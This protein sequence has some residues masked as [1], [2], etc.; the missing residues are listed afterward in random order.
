MIPLAYRVTDDHGRT[1]GGMVAFIDPSYFMRLYRLLDLDDGG[2]A[3]LL[4]RN[5]VLLTGYPLRPEWVGHSFADSALLASIR[6]ASGATMRDRGLLNDVPRV[7]AV[8]RHGNSPL[9]VVVSMTEHHVLAQWRETAQQFGS[10]AVGSALL[11]L[12][13]LFLLARQLGIAETARADLRQSAQRLDGIIQSAMDAIITVDQQ[14]RILLFN[15][16][17]ERVF[18][19]PAS[20]VIGSPLERFLPTRF[21][22]VHRAHVE[23]FGATGVTNRKMGDRMALAALR[24]DGEEFPIDASISQTIVGGEKVYTVILRDITERRRA[25]KEIEHS[26]RQLRELAAAMNNVREAERTRVARELHD[27]LA[28]WL[29]SLKM[30]VAWLAAR[31]PPDGSELI[32]RTARMGGII[33]ETVKTVRRIAADLRPAILNDLGLVAALEW[34]AQEFA[35]RSGIVVKLDMAQPELFLQE[36]LVTAVFRMV[37]ESLTNVA[38]HA[39]ASEVVIALHADGDTL[40]LRVSDNGYGINLAAL[41]ESRSYGLLGIRERAHTLGGAAEFASTPGEGFNVEIVIPLNP[42]RAETALP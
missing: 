41:S 20:E 3:M 12:F 16:A 26:H 42:Y 34:L 24:A 15:A 32:A 1:L 40:K 31:L 17:A 25:E 6:S 28:Q 35:Q 36:P 38:R 27:E 22:S 37:Q 10:G 5:G 19:Y 33:D 4:N 8:S 14:Q 30:D 23:H 7:T 2:R 9:V 18:G 39:H 13:L 29:T 21:R 11:I